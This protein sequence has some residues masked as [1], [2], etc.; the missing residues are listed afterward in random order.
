MANSLNNKYFFAMW[1]DHFSCGE[2]FPVYLQLV[3]KR[4][5]VYSK[6]LTTYENEKKKYIPHFVI[7]TPSIYVKGDHFT[8]IK[9][10][11]ASKEKE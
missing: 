9:Q 1:D 2:N 5:V 3:P 10:V 8:S 4:K 6:T 7:A 11:N